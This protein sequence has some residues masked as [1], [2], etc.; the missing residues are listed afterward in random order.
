MSPAG[1]THGTDEL[2]ERLRAHQGRPAAVAGRGRDPV[3]TPMIR[4][5][6]EALRH[7]APPDG[8]APATML[9]VWTMP[10]LDGMG[11]ARSPAYEALL[12]AL[13]D[14]G[15]TA[16]VATDCE[17]EYAQPLRPGDAVAFDGVIESVSPRKTTRLGTGYFVTTRTDIRTATGA[18]AGTHRFRIL[19]YRPERRGQAPPQA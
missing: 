15:Y 3:N 8:S 2:Y 17:Q 4:H 5:W 10:G 7:P 19:K 18:L 16:V 1:T 12:A 14:A 6:C 9:Q 11:G 13:D